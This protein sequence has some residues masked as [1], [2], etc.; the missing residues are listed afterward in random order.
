MYLCWGT[1]ELRVMSPGVARA[2]HAGM[3]NWPKGH[4]AETAVDRG[5]GETTGLKSDA[6]DVATCFYICQQPGHL[7]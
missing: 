1:T 4:E 7:S 6:G 3:C 5:V 2:G